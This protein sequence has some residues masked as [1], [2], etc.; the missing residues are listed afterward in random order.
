[1]DGFNSIQVGGAMSPNVIRFFG[2]LGITISILGSWSA[3]SKA[4]NGNEISGSKAEDFIS[5]Y[6]PDAGIPGPV[7]GAFTYCASWK[8]GKADCFVPA[9]GGQSNGVEASCELTGDGKKKKIS[10][11]DAQNFIDKNF[12]D[13][14]IPG[15][16]KGAYPFCGGKKTGKAD[17]FVPAMGGQSNGVEPSCEITGAKVKDVLADMAHDA[18]KDSRKG[19]TNAPADGVQ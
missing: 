13:A 17:C 19:Q 6:F 1:L 15:P 18:K 11:S 16:V 5:K 10:G 9:M 7:K 12:P 4:A 2:V 8:T 14:A 3:Y